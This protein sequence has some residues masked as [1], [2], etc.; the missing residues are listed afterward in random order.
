MKRF[1]SIKLKYY[2]EKIQPYTAKL[3]LT[4]ASPLMNY[5]SEKKALKWVFRKKRNLLE[6][7]ADE[8][9]LMIGK[10]LHPELFGNKGRVGFMELYISHIINKKIMLARGSS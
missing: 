4:K 5:L 10:I 8:K 3:V 6:A 2:K 1:Y 9:Y 7:Y